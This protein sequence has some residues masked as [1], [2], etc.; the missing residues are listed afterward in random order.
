MP[1]TALNTIN[2]GGPCMLLDNTTTLGGLTGDAIFFED[3]V[4]VVPNPKYREIPSSAA[5]EEDSTLIDLTYS[6]IGR[7]MAVWNASYR[8]VLL[9]N[10][11]DGSTVDLFNW[12]G[13][14]QRLIGAGNGGGNRFCSLIGADS[15]GFDFQRMVI[16][17][18]PGVFG[19][20]GKS[21]YDEAEWTAFIGNGFSLTAA[22]AF[23]QANT[24]A[25]ATALAAFPYPTTHQEQMCTGA[26][27]AV[28]G[29]DTVF[30]EDGFKLT[31]ELGLADVKMGGITWDKR[32]TKYRAMMAFQPQQPTVAQLLSAMNLQG[33][34]GGIG[35]R[36][37]ALAYD[38]IMSETGMS[39][40]VKSAALNRGAFVFDSK[41]NRP[42][43]F[44]MITAMTAPGTRLV[45][46]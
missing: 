28:T 8:K 24:T 29:W 11:A 1:T 30:G 45:F 17:K 42:G 36:L 13:A 5:G 22:N 46:A 35:S 12:T 9:P 15:N 32:I 18:P 21:L 19:G 34:G 37:S 25:W 16:T 20:L 6:I 44:G 26:W 43:E 4:R 2:V 39:I 40:T 33:A 41:V 10:T 23:M 3:A 7:P 27:G 31:H 38:F 14:G